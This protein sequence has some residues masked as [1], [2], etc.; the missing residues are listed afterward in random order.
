MDIHDSQSN[1]SGG[2]PQ[3]AYHIAGGEPVPQTGTKSTGLSGKR[4]GPGMSQVLTNKTLE[5]Q[6]KCTLHQISI[7]HIP[8]CFSQ[9][10]LCSLEFQLVIELKENI[11]PCQTHHYQLLSQMKGPLVHSP[12][13]LKLLCIHL[14][15]SVVECAKPMHKLRE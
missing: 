11:I 4:A 13:F 2:W 6:D 5:Y 7:E 8:K 15:S 1:E 3:G 9:L 10:Y 12:D 14:F